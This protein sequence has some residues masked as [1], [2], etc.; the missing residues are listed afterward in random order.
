MISHFHKSRRN[1]MIVQ[2]DARKGFSRKRVV[3]IWWGG[4][5]GNG[6]LM[7]VLG[8]LLKNSLHWRHTQINIKMVVSSDEAAAK[9]EANLSAM[10]A[11]MRVGFQFRILVANGESFWDIL[12]RESAGSDLVMMGL[13]PPQADFKAYYSRLKEN[14]RHL[15][16]RV[17]VLAAQ[18]VKFEEVLS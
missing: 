10:L 16:T 6:G 3:D 1:V 7:M 17:Y 13:A 18:D 9:A 2:D 12:Y 4:L 11:R 8:H 15:P 5:K 14:T